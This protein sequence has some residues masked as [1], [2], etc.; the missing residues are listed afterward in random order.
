[1][2]AFVSILGLVLISGCKGN[3]VKNSLGDLSIGNENSTTAKV[4][5]AWDNALNAASYNLYYSEFPGVT[6]YNGV[7]IR[8]VPN[9]VTVPNLNRNTTYYFV[10]TAENSHGES[11]ESNEVFYKID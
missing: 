1:L 10:V 6:K 7:P 5:L 11:D 9:P 2:F 8:D 3:E 4:T